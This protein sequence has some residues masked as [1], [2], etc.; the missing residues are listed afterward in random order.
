MA[1]LHMQGLRRIPNMS[2]YGSIGLNNA[3]IYLNI[4]DYVPEYA[5]INYSGYARVF[6]IPRYSY[7]NIIIIETNVVIITILVYSIC[8][9]RRSDTILSFFNTS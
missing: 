4:P 1:R 5:W 6:N 9:S 2:D 3:S 8:T 7:N